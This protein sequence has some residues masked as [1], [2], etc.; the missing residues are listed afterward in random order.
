[1]ISE[2]QINEVIKRIAENYHPDKII[3]FGS[4]AYGVPDKDSDLDLLIIKDDTS[5]KLERNRKVRR[6]LRDL[7]F[8][9]DV[10]VKT[11]HEFEEWRDIIGTIA[12]PAAKYG[13]MLYE[14]AR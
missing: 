11:N 1:M 5:P 8:P 10:I 6:Y 2:K 3:L 14:A 12:Y 13:K 4:Y 7:T 9:V